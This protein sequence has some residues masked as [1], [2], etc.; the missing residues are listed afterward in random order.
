MRSRGN[1]CWA[2]PPS[3]RSNHR[4]CKAT[5]PPCA[6]SNLSFCG[7]DQL[8]SALIR[9]EVK[10]RE[11]PSCCCCMYSLPL[12]HSAQP[13]SK[14]EEEAKKKRRKKKDSVVLPS[15][16]ACSPSR[17]SAEIGI[18]LERHSMHRKRRLKFAG[19]MKKLLQCSPLANERTSTQQFSSARAWQCGQR[20]SPG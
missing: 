8:C 11:R 17:S 6:G 14:S 18:C 7:L 10:C 4:R 1:A 9:S 5:D 2:T 3:P 16:L 20:L 19:E 13:E 15:S 12:W